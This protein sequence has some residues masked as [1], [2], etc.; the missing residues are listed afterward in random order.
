MAAFY[1]FAGNHPVLTVILA[2]IAMFTLSA[3]AEGIGNFRFV[4]K[5]GKGDDE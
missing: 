5:H 1:E 2:V 3:T 4:E